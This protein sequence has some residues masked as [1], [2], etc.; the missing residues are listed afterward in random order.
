MQNTKALSNFYQLLLPKLKSI[1]LTSHYLEDAS[2]LFVCLLNG[3]LEAIPNYGCNISTFRMCKA[4][5]KICEFKES[6]DEDSLKNHIEQEME[7]ASENRYEDSNAPK[8]INCADSSKVTGI[9]TKQTLLS[10]MKS[11]KIPLVWLM[12]IFGVTIAVFVSVMSVLLILNQ[13]SQSDMISHYLISIRDT[14]SMY[15]SSKR[16]AFHATELLA[17]IQDILV[18]PIDGMNKQDYLIFERNK[19]MLY[20]SQFYN[21]YKY[22]LENI[23]Y[24]K[25]SESYYQILYNTTLKIKNL[26]S[27][28]SFF[29]NDTINN[30]MSNIVSDI[31]LISES[32]DDY[33]MQTQQI[34][35]LTYIVWNVNN[36]LNY[37]MEKILDSLL[38][39]ILDMCSLS[40]N[41]QMLAYYCVSI[42]GSCA[43]FIILCLL[44][45]MAIKKKEEIFSLLL[46]VS[47]KLCLHMKEDCNIFKA[48][49]IVLR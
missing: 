36:P 42:I 12:N 47:P 19:I 49:I 27:G 10:Y 5:N 38:K 33:M 23:I 3:K 9:K 37:Q 1:K 15:I 24:L 6:T 17:Y 26:I 22:L 29:M 13:S 43:L 20:A 32:S 14:Y 39:E 4:P 40:K 44:V 8:K 45:Y 16:C 31:F 41:T 21:S 25:N 28:N 46:E 30:V 7:L 34:N 48:A 35:Y 11:T 2:N 18:Y